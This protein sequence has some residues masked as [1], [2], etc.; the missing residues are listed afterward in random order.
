MEWISLKVCPRSHFD[1]QGDVS[2]LPTRLAETEAPCP[3]SLPLESPQHTKW[4]QA[5]SYVCPIAS[6]KPLTSG[7]PIM[8]YIY[9]KYKGKKNPTCCV[10]RQ[11]VADL[12]FPTFSL[13]YEVFFFAVS[14]ASSPLPCTATF[15]FKRACTIQTPG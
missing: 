4:V 15:V 6:V 5:D 8:T 10:K 2:H 3:S 13:V 7:L 11:V 14:K 12:F 9:L 1:G